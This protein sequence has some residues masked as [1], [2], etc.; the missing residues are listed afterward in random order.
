REVRRRRD[1]GRAR[2]R[3]F[4]TAGDLDARRPDEAGRVAALRAGGRAT[5]PLH[6]ELAQERRARFDDARLDRDLRRLEIERQRELRDLGAVA[7]DVADDQRVRAR[8]DLDV[9]LRR[10]HVLELALELFRRRV[11]QRDDLGTRRLRFDRGLAARVLGFVF[12]VELL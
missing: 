5:A 2:L 4:V 10:Q 7:G 6:A 11:V 1:A 8:I 9:A 3:V 12:G